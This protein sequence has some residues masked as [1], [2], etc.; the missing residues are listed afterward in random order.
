MGGSPV[1]WILAHAVFDLFDLCCDLLEKTISESRISICVCVCVCVRA[2]PPRLPYVCYRSAQVLGYLLP[3]T[4]SSTWEFNHQPAEEA[5]LLVGPVC[6]LG[7]QEVSCRV[8][9]AGRG[10]RSDLLL[11]PALL[12]PGVHLV[13]DLLDGA[14]LLVLL[15]VPALQRRLVNRK[16]HLRLLH[17]RLLL[18]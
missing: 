12:Q 18:S 4:W 15:Q 10:Q 2:P 8:P 3:T 9:G 16:L 1:T 13:L 17:L 14:R 6:S 11:E 5:E 7:R